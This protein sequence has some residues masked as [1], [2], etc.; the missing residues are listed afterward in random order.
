[1]FGSK[2]QRDYKDII[3]GIKNGQRREPRHDPASGIEQDGT[4]MMRPEHRIV[5]DDFRQFGETLNVAMHHGPWSFEETNKVEFGFDG[6]DYGRHYRIWYNQ[7]PAGSLQIGVAH[8]LMATEGH[9]ANGEIDLDFPQL[10]PEG[11]VRD[12][13]RALSF[14]FMKN[15]DGP[16]MRAKADLE[17]LQIMSRHLWEVQREPDYVHSLHWRFEGPYEHYSEYLQPRQVL[18]SFDL[19]LG[20]EKA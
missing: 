8:L 12:M 14:M 16:T 2:I 6:P 1:M 18:P 7:L 5:W 13:L 17:V 9:G 19:D 11:E 4:T 20:P 10:A 15:D 3:H